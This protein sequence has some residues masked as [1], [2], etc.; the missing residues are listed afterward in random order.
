M[1]AADYNSFCVT[2]PVDSRLPGG[3][4]NQVCGL[5]DVSL[6][7]FGQVNN[8][9]Q[10]AENFGKQTQM[11]QGVDATINFRF[12]K[13]GY[14]A[15]GVS[16]GRTV[17]DNCEIA[18][19]PSVTSVLP[20]GNGGGAATTGPSTPAA[21]CHVAPPFSSGTQ[22]KFS[23]VYPLPW[24]L[25]TSAVVQSLPGPQVFASFVATNAQIAPS[26]GRNLAA[27]GTAAT[28]N[29]TVTVAN[30]MAPQS[31][32][33]DRLFQV[34]WRL[35]RNF[36][37]GAGKRVQANLDVFNIFNTAAVL[38]LTTR[39]GPQWLQPLEILGG[40]IAKL[41]FQLDL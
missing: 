31:Q 36:V 37:F 1:T 13:G 34:D 40:R 39:Y 3:G 7:R 14:V 12:G 38:R 29:A 5:A 25:K 4:G 35:S 16:T 10:P 19:N 30:I 22:V 24:D 32:F 28:C 41:G 11:Y 8:L 21:Y 17:T 33:E 2:A 20:S 26:L 6:A 27:C 15:G 18:K 23:G 9:I